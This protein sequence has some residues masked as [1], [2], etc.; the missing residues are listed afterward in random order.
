MENVAIQVGFAT[1][2][3]SYLYVRNNMRELKRFEIRVKM[4]IWGPKMEK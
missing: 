3:R 2:V 1:K 4:K